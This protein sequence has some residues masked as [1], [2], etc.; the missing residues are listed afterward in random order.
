M[1]CIIGPIDNFLKCSF[2]VGFLQNFHKIF[3]KFCAPLKFD[4]YREEKNIYH[5]S[6]YIYHISIYLSYIYHISIY[7]SYIYISNI[8]IHVSIIYLSYIYISIIY[9]YIYHISIHLSYIYISM[10]YRLLAVLYFE[11][12]P[13]Q[14]RTQSQQFL[15]AEKCEWHFSRGQEMLAVLGMRLSRL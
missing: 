13:L 8:Y 5:I 10:G 2:R 7:L 4:Y 15:A 6:M 3:Q 1:F 12:S 14:S 9:L 11:W